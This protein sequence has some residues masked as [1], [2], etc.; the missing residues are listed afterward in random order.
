MNTNLAYQD[1][2]QRKERINGKVVAMSPRPNVNHNRISRNLARLFSNYL[3]GKP[4]EPFGDGVELFLSDKDYFI[5][6]FMVVCDP[7]KIKRDGVHGAPDLVAEILSPS[8]AKNDRSYKKEVYEKAGVKEYWIISPT[9][10]SVE[11]YFLEEG[12]F[13]LQD[14][15]S[16]RPE[17]ELERMT[18]EE[19]AALPT[20]FKCSLYDDLLISLKDIFSRVH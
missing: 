6:D 1:E 10:K 4:C 3:D 16:I 17:W 15:Y 14:V 5:P 13:V 12:R 8:T 9:D 2:L 7:D 11:Q 20:E 19:R 18:E